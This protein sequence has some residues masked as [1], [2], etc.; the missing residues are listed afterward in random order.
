MKLLN[1]F[2]F[3]VILFLFIGCGSGQKQEENKPVVFGSYHENVMGMVSVYTFDHYTRRLKQG[4]GF[5]ISPN[6]VVAPLSLVQGAFR[7]RIAPLGTTQMFEVSGYTAYD[8]KRNLVTLHAQRKN[9][10]YIQQDSGY[11]EGDTLYTLFRSSNKLMTRKTTILSDSIKDSTSYIPLS[12]PM[13]VGK[14]AFYLNHSLAGMIAEGVESA[15]GVRVIEKSVIDSILKKQESYPQPVIDLSRKTDKVYTSHELIYGVRII[16]QMGS[17]VV[18]LFDETPVYRDNFIKLVEDQFY[19]SLLIHRVLKGF[20]IQTGAADTRY[21]TSE[22]V[23]GWQGPGYTLPMKIVSGKFH[24]RGAVAASK[25][26]DARNPKN[27]SDGSQFYIVSGR[28][29]TLQELDEIENQKGFRFSAQQRQIYTSIGGAP[30]LDN[31]YTVFGEVVSG[32]DVVDRISHVETYQTDRPLSD[33]RIIRVE[34][35]KK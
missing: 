3:L 15:E 17:I 26:P 30:H 16:T 2:A 23:V 19:D 28:I 35:I 1:W 32:M 33:I 13:E 18:K 4:Y 14:P 11:P 6:V 29:F 8:L 34:I 7:V 21:A 22:D 10:N 20:L 27:T 12:T 24:R 5:Y 9:A 31:D 25:L